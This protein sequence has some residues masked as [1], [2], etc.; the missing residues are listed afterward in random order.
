M[1]WLWAILATASAQVDE[2]GATLVLGQGQDRP[3]LLTYIYTRC[4]MPEFCPAT[5]ARLQPLQEALTKSQRIVAV[6]L[7]PEFDTGEVLTRYG[8]AAAADPARWSFGIPTKAQL[9][10]LAMRS[11][12]QVAEGET[13]QASP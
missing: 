12:L 2:T 10:D 3:T 7:D 6:T 5:I 8:E 4:P 9:P 1:T 11:G 13:G